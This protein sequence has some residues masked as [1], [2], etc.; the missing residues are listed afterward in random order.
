MQFESGMKVSYTEFIGTI[1]FIG[2]KY[3]TFIPENSNVSLLIYKQDWKHVTVL[4]PS[5]TP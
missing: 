1:D 4:E 3:V 2:K 5:T